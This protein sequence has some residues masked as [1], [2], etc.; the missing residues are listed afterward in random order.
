LR[1]FDTVLDE[2]DGGA[3]EFVPKKVLLFLWYRNDNRATLTTV[4]GLP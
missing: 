2:E 4:W 1:V 3:D